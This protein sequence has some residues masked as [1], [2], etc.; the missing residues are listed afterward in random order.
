MSSNKN[1]LEKDDAWSRFESAVAA[2]V[3]G[4]PKH[5]IAPENGKKPKPLSGASSNGR[6]RKPA[7]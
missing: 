4:K 6:K 3:K 1:G 2:A 5:K 7:S